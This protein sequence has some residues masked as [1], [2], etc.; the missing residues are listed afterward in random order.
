MSSK[1]KTV[2][3][4]RPRRRRPYR[5]AR[6]SAATTKTAAPRPP[7]DNTP[8]VHLSACAKDYVRCLANPTPSGCLACVPSNHPNFSLPTRCFARGTFSVGTSFNGYIVADPLKAAFN[9]T[10]CIIMNGTTFNGT[11]IALNS[12]NNILAYSNS[13]Y[14]VTNLDNDG[15]G[16]NPRVVAALLRIRYVGT[17]LNRSGTAVCLHD[18]THSTLFGRTSSE[19]DAE[20]QSNRIHIGDKWINVNYAPVYESDYEFRNIPFPGDSIIPNIDANSQF[21]YMGAWLACGAASTF[22]YEFWTVIEFQGKNVRGQKLSHSDPVALSAGVVSATNNKPH[23]LPPTVVEKNFLQ[24]AEGYI[25][26]GT[27]YVADAKKLYNA[28]KQLW[29]SL[30]KWNYTASME[31]L[32][33]LAIE[34]LS[35]L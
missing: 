5:L 11:T 19:L 16:V 15:N 23:D 9:D 3:K 4:R 17:L 30:P 34:G 13:P 33:G 35:A 26:K 27:S 18:P 7:M 12:A 22:E 8:V 20:V 31:G 10:P 2:T 28:G 1:P 14:V 32:E 21:W 6:S 29:S 25:A 24:K